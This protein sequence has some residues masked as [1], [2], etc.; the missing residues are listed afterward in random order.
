MSLKLHKMM[1]LL[2]EHSDPVMNNKTYSDL[3]HGR[4]L[5]AQS[6]VDLSF[7]DVPI[8]LDKSKWSHVE[9]A[10]GEVLSRT[11][12]FLNFQTLFYFVSESLKLQEKLN[13][14]CV[15]KIDE[16]IVSTVLQTKDI[17]EVTELDIMLSER[18]NDIYEDT[19]YFHSVGKNERS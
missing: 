5:P 14:H 6:I 1:S 15:M 4:P 3:I 2:N 16:L 19:Q 18:I 10:S 17:Q 11:F 12:N 13:H 8:T 7:E 9:A